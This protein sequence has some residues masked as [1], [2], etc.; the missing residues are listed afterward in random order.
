MNCW[1]KGKDSALN[2]VLTSSMG[3]STVLATLY[4]ATIAAKRGNFVTNS[5]WEQI[6]KE[7]YHVSL[8]RCSSLKL[9][10]NFLLIQIFSPKSVL[11]FLIRL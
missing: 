5:I 6:P 8:K 11:V 3:V 1:V 9:I 10:K 4:R 2:T 7:E